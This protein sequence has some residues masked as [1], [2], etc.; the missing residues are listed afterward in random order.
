MRGPVFAT[1]DIFS[2]G[3]NTMVVSI[4]TG[5]TETTVVIGW[6]DSF[7][8]KWSTESSQSEQPFSELESCISP[9]FIA[10]LCI[11]AISLSAGIIIDICIGQIPISE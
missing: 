7:S 1:G 11:I 8:I 9:I 4:D 3:L 6:V 2:R 10:P 5:K